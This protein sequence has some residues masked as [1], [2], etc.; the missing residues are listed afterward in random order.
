MV[1]RKKEITA[2]RQDIVPEDNFI[3]YIALSNV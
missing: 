3:Q 1:V 2:G